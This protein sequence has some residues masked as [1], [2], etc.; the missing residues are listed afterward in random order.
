LAIVKD[1]MNGFDLTD[2]KL[3]IVDAGINN[4]NVGISKRINIDYAQ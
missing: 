2:G 3:R 4:L 1:T